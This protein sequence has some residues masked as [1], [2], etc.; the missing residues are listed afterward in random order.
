MTPAQALREAAAE[1]RRLAAD[2]R[3]NNGWAEHTERADWLE[4]RADRLAGETGGGEHDDAVLGLVTDGEQGL[5]TCSTQ[6]VPPIAVLA[7][8]AVK[9]IRSFL[10]V[11]G[12]GQAQR[13]D[14]YA[15]IWG[16]AAAHNI[17]ALLTKKDLD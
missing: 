7:E 3:T 17:H 2:A 15:A 12:F 8:V 4:E 9:A 11:D 14:E 1:Q 13:L 10:P 16:N 5:G 6:P